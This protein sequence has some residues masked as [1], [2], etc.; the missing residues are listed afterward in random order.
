[1][2]TKTTKTIVPCDDRCMFAKGDECDCHCE[3]V[4]HQQGHRLTAAQREILRT[5]AGRRVNPLKPRTDEYTLGREMFKAHEDGMT[6][7]DI[8]KMYDVS[9]PTVRRYITRYLLGREV[10]L[11][12][13]AKA[14]AKHVLAA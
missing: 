4:N 10:Y 2:S 11:A 5:K 14:K 8:A 12:G 6:K 1:M 3:G 9:A 7:R 13:A